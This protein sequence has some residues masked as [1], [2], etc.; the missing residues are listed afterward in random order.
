MT[1]ATHDATAVL[2][3]EGQLNIPAVCCCDNKVVLQED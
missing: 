3:A 1:Q 2:L